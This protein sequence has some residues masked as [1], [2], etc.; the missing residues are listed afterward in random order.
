MNN[1]INEMEMSNEFVE[2]NKESKYK[3]YAIV[4][5]LYILVIILTVFLVIGLKNQKEVVINQN[6]NIGL[7]NNI[8]L[9]TFKHI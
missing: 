8:N 3:T 7:N 5:I 9:Q 2:I 4:I 1:E 6:N